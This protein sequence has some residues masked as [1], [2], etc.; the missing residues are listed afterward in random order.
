MVYVVYNDE[1]Y[2]HGVKGMKWGVRRYQNDDGTRTA[3]GKKRYTDGGEKKQLS[4]EERAARNA[5]IKSTAKKV[6]VGVGVAALVA[7]GTY[8]AVKYNNKTMSEAKSLMS[9]ARKER[10]DRYFEEIDR[11]NEQEMFSRKMYDRSTSA[12]QKNQWSFANAEAKGRMA[13]ALE[14]REIYKRVSERKMADKSV[15]RK[16]QREVI[17]RDI[18]NVRDRLKD[19]SK[20]LADTNTKKARSNISGLLEETAYEKRLREIA[21]EHASKIKNRR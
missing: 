8:A 4:D 15:Q 10:L 17:K 13:E 5:K 19:R 3:A 2:H 18:G 16:A 11:A 7:A 20:S 6:A 14:N 21:D 1:L 9:S 12:P